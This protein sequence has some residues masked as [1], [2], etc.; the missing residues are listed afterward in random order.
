MSL[1]CPDCPH[2]E[3]LGYGGDAL[4]SGE[5]GLS[6]FDLSTFYEK[7]V[8]DY[9][10]ARRANGGFTETAPFVSMANSGMGGDSGPIGWQTFQPAAQ[11]WLYKYFGNKRTLEV[12]WNRTKQFMEFLTTAP[13]TG[14]G[15]WM[16]TER[17]TPTMTAPLFQ[18]E[19]FLAAANIS[20][21]LGEPAAEQTR[22]RALAGNALAGFTT[23]FLNHSTG[24]YRAPG[25]TDLTQ[26]GQAA[27][28]FMGIVPPASHALALARLV[29]SVTAADGH[30]MTGMFGVKW[31]LMAL[32]ETGNVDLAYAALT[33]TSFPSYGFMLANGS[34]TVWEGWFFSAD[35]YSHDHP[36]FGSAI[37]FMSQVLGGIQ[38]HPA[39]KGF[40]RV[41][42]KP[43]PPKGL[44]HF[45]A[46]FN[47]MRGLIVVKWSWAQVP[48][49]VDGPGGTRKLQLH[50]HV[51]PNVAAE[52]HVPTTGGTA[53]LDHSTGEQTAAQHGQ[54]ATVLTRGSGTH[55]F[56][57]WVKA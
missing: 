47:S 36:A 41:L 22:W 18:H 5:A 14:L 11:L 35:M 52:I 57:S 28:I 24:V 16:P 50:V 29:D 31:F 34:T 43:R 39:A 42:I 44:A 2:R 8:V 33:K 10:D 45:Q 3:R 54:S 55:D 20:L 9:S 37:T 21:I 48:G 4:A 51:P 7:R 15:D 46:S 32:A 13:P 27:P 30:M 49:T 38:P 25:R 6:I 1:C 19:C 56:S 40:D 26:C 12:N 23:K 53:V 17:P